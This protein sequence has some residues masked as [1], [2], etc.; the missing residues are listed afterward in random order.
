VIASDYDNDG[1]PDLFAANDGMEIYLYHNNHDGTFTESGLMAGVGL[2]EDGNTMAAMCLSVGDYDN[3]GLLDLYVSDFQDVPHHL[4][5]NT[6]GGTSR[7]SAARQA[8]PPS[9]RA[10]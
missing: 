10:S 1:W 8:S 4:W 9:P 7:K 2:N 3:D 6:G 5:R